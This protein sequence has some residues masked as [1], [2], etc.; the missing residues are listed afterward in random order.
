MVCLYASMDAF[1]LQTESR[2][3]GCIEDRVTWEGRT[4][5]KTGGVN[6]S[7]CCRFHQSAPIPPAQAER[8]NGFLIALG[9]TR[10]FSLMSIKL[11]FKGKHHRH[12]AEVFSIDSIAAVVC[13]TDNNLTLLS[14]RHCRQLISWD[15]LNKKY[16]HLRQRYVTPKSS[17][18]GLG[19]AVH[20]V[21][22]TASRSQ[23]PDKYLLDLKYTSERITTAATA[24]S[25]QSSPSFQAFLYFYLIF[26]IG[27][28]WHKRLQCE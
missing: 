7:S 26:C 22:S 15:T 27:S 28:P 19:T 5:F 13:W 4:G 20:H 17:S 18:K 8:T 25:R 2:R 21:L 3:G 11:N 9:P 12:H 14:L 24:T 10:P 23:T 16:C 1:M 6:S